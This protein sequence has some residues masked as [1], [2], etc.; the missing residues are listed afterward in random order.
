M[1]ID[2]L[3]GI[4][5]PCS[6]RGHARS[7]PAEPVVRDTV[8]LGEKAAFASVTSRS[9]AD[10]V[11][12][13]EKIL[14]SSRGWKGA[15]IVRGTIEVPGGDLV[16]GTYCDLRKI[17]RRDGVVAWEKDISAGSRNLSTRPAVLA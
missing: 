13:A 15:G 10:R 17:A 11:F 2:G 1:E 12:N 14:W 4:H 3:P 9:I 5:S 8:S 7:A 6:R 16:S